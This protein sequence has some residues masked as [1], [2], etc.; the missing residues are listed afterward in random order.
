MQLSLSE[1]L[2]VKVSVASLFDET[3]LEVGATTFKVSEDEWRQ[4]AAR[5]VTDTL[6]YMPATSILP[7]IVGG[8]SV[9]IRGYASSGS[10]K[11]LATLLD[12]VHINNFANGSAFIDKP[13]IAWGNLKEVEFI[14][15]PGSGLYGSDAFHGV[16]SMHSYATSNDEVDVAVN[17]AS[18]G[19]Y[20]A[21]ARLSQSLLPALR[22]QLATSASGQQD[23]TEDYRYTDPSDLTQKKGVRALKYNAQSLIAKLVSDGVTPIDFRLGLYYDTYE[24]D[25]FYGVGT[26]FSPGVSEL[27]QRDTSDN[28]SEFSM[29]NFF[30]SGETWRQL[31]WELNGFYWRSNRK[32]RVNRDT[33]FV[34]ADEDEL[35]Y[36]LNYLIKYDKPQANTH[37]LFSLGIDEKE[38]A[39]DTQ[40]QVISYEGDLLREGPRPYNDIEREILNAFYQGKSRF[41]QGK[42]NVIY[43]IRYDDYSDFGDQL[44]PRL[45]LIFQPQSQ[46]AVKLLYGNAFR[47]AIASEV[48]GVPNLKGSETLKPETLDSLELV[49]MHQRPQWRAE[50]VLYANRWRDGIVIDSS[51]DPNFDREYV[52]KGEN[53]AQGLECSYL[54][55][56]KQL[57]LDLSLSYVE[58]ENE[59][60]GNDFVMF[61]K[62][63]GVLGAGYRWPRQHIQLYI[64]NRIHYDVQSY[65]LSPAISESPDLPH[66]WR[67]DVNLTKR[68]GTDTRIYV[69]IRNLFDRDN[70]WATTVNTENGA[71][72]EGINVELGVQRQWH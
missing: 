55:W 19:Y 32:T 57:R 51:S 59:L 11:G 13:N 63:I 40:Q 20:S 65:E 10:S 36:G 1:L 21:S 52:N 50:L 5:S 46:T 15:G 9:A 64:N 48:S 60:T 4:R 72:D 27:E 67:T 39:D 44:T 45:G 43:G 18:T 42:F 22:L 66:Y 16:V 29:A 31:R 49:V 26:V 71:P 2:S 38:V 7:T 35:R 69:N 17:T 53:R 30:I 54:Y 47:A 58:S 68:F 41:W 12:G 8:E 33:F 6:L 24:A 28:D 56:G 61:P 23:Q 34:A 62:V 37:W 14:R 70:V 25:Q 3:L